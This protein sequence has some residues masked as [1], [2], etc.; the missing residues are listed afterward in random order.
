MFFLLR[1]AFWLGLV[2]VLLPSGAKTP[3]ASIDAAQAVTAAS[4]A[5]H[6]MSGFC[7]RQPE[8]CAAGGK[9][10]AA[11]GHKAE[12]GARTLFGFI[13]ARLSAKSAPAESAAPVER[14]TGSIPVTARGTLTNADLKPV[15]HAPVPL[16]PRRAAQTAKPSA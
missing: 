14:T 9:V 15:W 2:C 1:M 13:S 5:V 12:A 16:P 10:A 6:D 8:A 4:A 3:D 11:I 7:N